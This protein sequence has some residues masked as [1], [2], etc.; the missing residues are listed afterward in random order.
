MC[1]F[2]GD[3]S[4]QTHLTTVS[5]YVLKPALCDCLHPPTQAKGWGEFFPAGLQAICFRTDIFLFINGRM[6]LGVSKTYIQTQLV[7]R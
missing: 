1:R 4:E 5:D 3:M 7:W 2:V 6:R